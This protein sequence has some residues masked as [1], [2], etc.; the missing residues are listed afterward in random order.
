MVSLSNNYVSMCVPRNSQILRGVMALVACVSLSHGTAFAANKTLAVPD[1][2]S[3]S[4]VSGNQ[5][6]T[7]PLPPRQIEVVV[8]WGFRLRST[9]HDLR[10]QSVTSGYQELVEKPVCLTSLCGFVVVLDGTKWRA[11]NVMAGSENELKEMKENMERAGTTLVIVHP[12]GVK[13]QVPEF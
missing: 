11:T 10:M 6:L 2:G 8:V 4:Q 3:A 13:R 1:T 5:P 7:A 12:S 9:E